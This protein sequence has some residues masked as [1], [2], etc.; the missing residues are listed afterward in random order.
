MADI[1]AET[2][3]NDLSTELA[4]D[5]M[6][7]TDVA[8]KLDSDSPLITTALEQ[9]EGHARAMDTIYGDTLKHATDTAELAMDGGVPATAVPRMLEVSAIHYKTA[10]EAQNSKV[11][12]TMK[13]MKL[14]NESK[15]IDLDKQ[16][17]YHEMGN[18]P[19]DK[20]DVI[21]VEDRNTLLKR[22]KEEANTGKK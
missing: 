4:D 13:M 5:E 2:D 16:K 6:V 3:D 15:K 8:L 10:M 18:A 11:E 22:L 19:T 17:L 7:T 9:I 20:A 1:L 12:A 14:I 21:L